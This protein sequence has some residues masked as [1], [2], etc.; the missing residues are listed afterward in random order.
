MTQKEKDR[1][2]I[3]TDTQKFLSEG[4]KIKKSKSKNLSNFRMVGN[5]KGSSEVYS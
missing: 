2:R 5:I 4:G 3:A 1:I